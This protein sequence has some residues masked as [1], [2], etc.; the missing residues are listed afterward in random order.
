MDKIEIERIEVDN[1]FGLYSYDIRSNEVSP[2]QLIILY[3]D[4]GCGKTTILKSIFYLLSVRDEAGDK[5]RLANTKFKKFIVHINNDISIGAIRNEELIGS[6]TYI[7]AQNNN[8]KFEVFLQA[9]KTEENEYAINLKDDSDEN[10]LLLKMYEY[11]KQLNLSIFYLSYDRKAMYGTRN[12][13]QID[14]NKRERF[15]DGLLQSRIRKQFYDLRVHDPIEITI[16]NL[17]D[18]IRSRAILATKIGD[19]KTNSIYLELVKKIVEIDIK[20]NND[21]DIMVKEMQMLINEVNK[22]TD[23]YADL[24]LI[25]F[26]A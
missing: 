19:R 26:S 20:G 6:Y 25:V 9:N 3:G 22:R 4:N 18:W 12:I 21:I 11:I 16:K 14:L 24:G 5:T 13:S 2:N 10:Q 15:P 1:L 17:E 7:I 8:T 23:A